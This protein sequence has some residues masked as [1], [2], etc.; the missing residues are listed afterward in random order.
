MRRNVG[1]A[2]V[3]NGKPGSVDGVGRDLPSAGQGLLSDTGR[4]G[5]FQGGK[6]AFVTA[7]V[8][9]CLS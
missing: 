5:E 2:W 4:L 6:V 3:W 9:T 7:N 1:I 8:G